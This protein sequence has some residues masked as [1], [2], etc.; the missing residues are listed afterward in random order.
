MELQHNI[1]LLKSEEEKNLIMVNDEGLWVKFSIPAAARVVAY[2]DQCK[3]EMHTT[4]H[5]PF[6]R[7]LAENY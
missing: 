2:F 5:V 6:Q 4:S 3:P 1:G 7:S